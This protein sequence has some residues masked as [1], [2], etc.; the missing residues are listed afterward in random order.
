MRQPAF[1]FCLT[2][3]KVTQPYR[4]FDHRTSERTIERS[5]ERSIKRSI[6]LSIEHSIERRR[7]L[8][9][10]SQENFAEELASGD[11]EFHKQWAYSGGDLGFC[12]FSSQLLGLLLG[13]L[14]GMMDGFLPWLP[15]LPCWMASSSAC[16]QGPFVSLSRCRST[17]I[18]LYKKVGFPRQTLPFSYFWWVLY[19]SGS[20]FLCQIS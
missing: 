11:T 19:S 9:Q 17:P 5:I 16:P 10:D 13:F 6:G 20:D 15:S 2:V 4:T 8:N 14:L 3:T 1:M 18:P 7:K 12:S